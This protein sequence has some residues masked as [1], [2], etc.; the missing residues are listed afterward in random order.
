MKS[1]SIEEVEADVILIGVGFGG[2]AALRALLE[3]GLRVAA[4]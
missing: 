2:F 3:R 1:Y 4:I